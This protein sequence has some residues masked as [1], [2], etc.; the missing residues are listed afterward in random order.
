MKTIPFV[1]PWINEK[2]LQSALQS[3]FV[4]SLGQASRQLER[5]FE[6]TLKVKRAMLVGSCTDAL[7]IA[8]MSLNLK[9]TDEVI[10]PSFTFV[11]TVNS[12]I[13]AGGKA[14]F[15]DIEPNTLGLNPD[16]VEKSVNKKTKAIVV[17]H[18]GGISAQ[19]EKIKK[20]CIRHK[21]KLIE[22]AAQGL[23]I[24]DN[25]RYLGTFGDVGCFSFHHTKNVTCGE[26]GLLVIPSDGDLIT[27][28]EEIRSFGTDKESF[29][30]GEVD[31]YEWQRIGGSYF[32]TDVQAALLK[33]QIDKAAKIQSERKRVY[34]TYYRNLR[35]LEKIQVEVSRHPISSNFH[36]FWLVC[37]SKKERDN[38][39]KVLRKGGIQASFHFLPLHD[40]PFVRRN[41]NKFRIMGDMAVTD[42][43]S[44]RI[45]RLPIF[46][47]LKNKEI[48]YICSK[49]L[50]FYKI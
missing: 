14:V 15:V 40:S 2:E 31:K 17:V 21:L 22:D 9:K 29:L 18:Y 47:Q 36:L 11:S 6:R 39:L 28:C 33:T 25:N 44:G 7:E 8:F 1:K 34:G 13:K 48:D 5:D 3:K 26:G 35:E 4:N 16:K 50:A 37:R 49:I 30:R 46:P 32:M 43:V 27:S 19:V 10:C 12:I 45:L 20:I 42:N 41:P 24:K 23:F 38:L